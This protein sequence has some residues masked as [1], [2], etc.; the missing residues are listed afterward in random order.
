MVQ[1]AAV[2]SCRKLV[3]K[4]LYNLLLL[5]RQ[6]SAL[7]NNLNKLCKAAEPLNQPNRGHGEQCF[8]VAAH[9]HGG[10]G[11]MLVVIFS[12]L[13]F[14]QSDGRDMIPYLLLDTYLDGISD[15]FFSPIHFS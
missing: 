15:R 10:V 13:L 5:K 6:Q 2:S 11:E 3:N 8:G 12:P 14:A 7:G 4:L 1:D 9:P